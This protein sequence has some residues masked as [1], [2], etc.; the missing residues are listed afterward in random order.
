MK[1]EFTIKVDVD[2][3]EY[4]ASNMRVADKQ[5]S[6]HELFAIWDYITFMILNNTN[7]VEQC[8]VC[9]DKIKEIRKKEVYDKKEN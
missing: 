8:A 7:D 5:I 2:D 6:Y 1:K 4:H 3:E 9:M